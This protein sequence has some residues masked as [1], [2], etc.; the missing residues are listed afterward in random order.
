LSIYPN[1]NQL[2]WISWNGWTHAMIFTQNLVNFG[3]HQQ[4]ARSTMKYEYPDSPPTP[5]LGLLLELSGAVLSSQP[6]PPYR[7]NHHLQPSPKNYNYN[8]P[9]PGLLSL[10]QQPLCDEISK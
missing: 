6:S 1:E 4:M 9:P 5:F 2:F 10:L 7:L 3:I 8:S